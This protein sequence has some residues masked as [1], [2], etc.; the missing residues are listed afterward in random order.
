MNIRYLLIRHATCARMDDIL[1]GRVVDSPLDVNGAR[2]AAGLATRLA[3]EADLCVDV[4][5]RRRTLQT[6]HAIAAQARAEVRL[7]PDV[8]EIDFGHWSGTSFAQLANDAQWR[9]WNER[10][11]VAVTPAGD[12]IANVQSRLASHLHRLQDTSAGRT[13]AIVTHAEVIR[14]AL[15][16]VLQLPATCYGKFEI[17]P[18]SITSL[19]YRDGTYVVQAVNERVAA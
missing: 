10:R 14:S 6:A 16:W 19:C 8:D 13:V 15:L 11:D 1:F 18:A 12:S 7:A 9:R 3:L 2:Q 5:P 17:A 4:S